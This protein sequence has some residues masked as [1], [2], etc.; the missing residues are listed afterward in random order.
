MPP[1]KT[2][3]DKLKGTLSSAGPL[4][5]S[6]RG[7]AAKVPSGSLA[8]MLTAGPVASIKPSESIVAVG[9]ELKIAIQDDRLR[10]DKD[11]LFHLQY[12]SNVLHLKALI[13]AEQIQHDQ[14]E[15]SSSAVAEAIVSFR[16]AASAPRASTGGRTVTARFIAKAPGVSPI[17]VALMN[18]SGDMV[19]DAPPAGKGVVR[20]R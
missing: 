10:P 3:S 15:P 7:V 2:K 20:V 16:V 4:P 5:M 9:K 6:Q 18:A 1:H 17:R 8:K 13:D 12:D 19:A 11:S 14:P